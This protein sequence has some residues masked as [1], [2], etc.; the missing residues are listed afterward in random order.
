MAGL[1][2]V[3]QIVE[4]KTTLKLWEQLFKSMLNLTTLDCFFNKV[5]YKLLSLILLI[6]L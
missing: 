6:P 3:N 5:C 2:K 4:G 1:L